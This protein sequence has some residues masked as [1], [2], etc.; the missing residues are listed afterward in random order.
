MIFFLEMVRGFYGR[1]RKITTRLGP[2]IENVHLP[3]WHE[4]PDIELY[5]DQ[6]IT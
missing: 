3:R 2:T 1:D 4:L 6:V 5:M